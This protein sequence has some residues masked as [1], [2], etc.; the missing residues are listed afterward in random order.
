MCFAGHS[1][2]DT[3]TSSDTLRH[4]P[5]LTVPVLMCLSHLSR[6]GQTLPALHTQP[7]M[8][9]YIQVPGCML[10]ETGCLP[11]IDKRAHTQGFGRPLASWVQLG[12]NWTFGALG[13]GIPYG[14]GGIAPGSTVG[15]GGM[16]VHRQTVTDGYSV[17]LAACL[18]SHKCVCCD[19]LALQ[20]TV[21]LPLSS[22]W[23]GTGNTVAAWGPLLSPPPTPASIHVLALEQPLLFNTALLPSIS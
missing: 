23:M 4:H 14:A 6:V 10:I 12:T 13:S 8:D 9:T 1:L 2:P 18:T 3:Y 19:I 17:T 22:P 20:T 15:T 21:S 7:D 16:E 11:H 5:P